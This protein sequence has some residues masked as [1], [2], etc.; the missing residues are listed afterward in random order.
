MTEGAHALHD[1]YI[2]PV[3]GSVCVCVP[4]WSNKSLT[5]PFMIA[6]I[7]L[8]K[9]YLFRNKMH[10]FNTYAAQDTIIHNDN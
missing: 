4:E 5:L 3:K 9:R 7:H 2:Q 10:H 8:M 1:F 6:Q